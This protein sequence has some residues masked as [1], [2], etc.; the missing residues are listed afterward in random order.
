[1]KTLHDNEL[2]RLLA[3]VNT[4]PP[5][6]RQAFTLRKVYELSYAEIAARLHITVPEVERLLA[7]AVV[8]LAESLESSSDA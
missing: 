8:K 3:R 4:L 6:V 7:E 2:T 5:A 1:M